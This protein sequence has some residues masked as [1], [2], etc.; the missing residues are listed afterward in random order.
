MLKTFEELDAMTKPFVGLLYAVLF[1][2]VFP[3][4]PEASTKPSKRTLSW[5]TFPDRVL[6]EAEERTN[7]SNPLPE[8]VLPE[9]TFESLSTTTNPSKVTLFEA[10]LPERMLP[11]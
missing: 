9:R 3:S 7:P 11:F 2:R 5:A 8:A 4:E 10:L 1:V 6:L